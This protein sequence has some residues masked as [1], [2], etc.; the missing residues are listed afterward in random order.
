MDY[1]VRA[2]VN[3]T[4]YIMA[5][6]GGQKWC[7]SSV[8]KCMAESNAAAASLSSS[9]TIL[10]ANVYWF[11]NAIRILVGKMERK[12]QQQQQQKFDVNVII[13]LWCLSGCVI[14]WVCVRSFVV[15]SIERVLVASGFVLFCF[16]W[17]FDRRKSLWKQA[18]FIFRCQFIWLKAPQ[19]RLLFLTYPKGSRWAQKDVK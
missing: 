15:T 18:T 6:Y 13:V 7:G 17:I 3:E 4:H 12:K 9:S 2:C 16:V 10:L 8:C 14:V 11:F 19:R 5:C 1:F